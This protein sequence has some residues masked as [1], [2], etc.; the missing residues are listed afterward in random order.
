MPTTEQELLLLLGVNELFTKRTLCLLCYNEFSYDNKFCPQRCST[1]RSSIA[2]IYDSNVELIIQKI[3]ARQS[4]NFNEHK[5]NIYNNTDYEKT[6]DI[7]F[8]TLYQYVLKQNGYQDLISLLLHADGIGITSSTKL[9]MWMLSGSIVELPAKLR[10]RQ[11]NMVII[12]IWIAYIEPPAKLWLN[13]SVNKLQIIKDQGEHMNK[14]R[15]YR[16][17]TVRLRTTDQYF[18]L[19]KKA[20]L[21]QSNIRGHLGESVLNNILDVEFPEAIVLDYLHVSLLGHAKLII[22]SVYKQLK[23]AQR[24]ELNSYLRNQFFPHFFNRKLRSIDNFGFVK[25]TEVSNV[26]FYGLLPHLISFM[27]IEQYS[28]L[29]LYVC[30]MRL[31]H[32]GDVFDDKTS[33]VADQLFTEFYKDHELFYKTSQSL[34][35]HLHAHFASLYE[36]HGSLCNLGCF[37]QESFIGSVSSN[38]HGTQFYGDS[39]THFYNIDFAIQDKKKERQNLMDLMI[40]RPHRQVIMTIY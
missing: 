31:L 9:K 39:I 12:S 30:A 23:P 37:G 35:L 26:L 27:Q 40:K 4:S 24:K 1:D 14:K 7:P 32:S 17:D 5:K 3:I 29:A 22:L 25:A 19:S 36:T 11:C 21:T 28:H 13:Y 20:E 8:G 10:S 2:C 6:K 33:E 34:K 38:H 18:K 16:Y 15:Q